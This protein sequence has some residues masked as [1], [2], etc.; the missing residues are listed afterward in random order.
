MFSTNYSEE[1]L[2]RK[3]EKLELALLKFHKIELETFPIYHLVQTS[4]PWKY[5]NNISSKLKTEYTYSLLLIFWKIQI[6]A[7]KPFPQTSTNW[8]CWNILFF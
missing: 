4:K 5:F 6:E 1:G 8:G 7:A 2:P 3:K